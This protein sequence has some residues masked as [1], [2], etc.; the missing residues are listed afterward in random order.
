[1]T[2]EHTIAV[3][4]EPNPADMQ[5]LI[6]GLLEFNTAQL[7]GET[8][9]YLVATVRDK[10]GLV[11]GGIFAVTYMAWLHVQVVWLHESLR[12]LGY[13][14]ALMKL[15]EEEAI[16]RGCMNAF[17]ET[18]NFQALPFYQKCGYTIFSTLRDMPPGG[19]RYA[20]TKE[21]QAALPGPP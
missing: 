7:G 6:K 14:G 2:A 20:L 21:L 10:T 16:Q 8:Q 12:G 4:L 18:L 17:V 3:E 1:M 13:G 9:K 15:A 19:A 5:V 11:V